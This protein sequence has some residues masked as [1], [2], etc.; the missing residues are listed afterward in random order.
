M[1]T[2]D[3]TFPGIQ[4]YYTTLD[5]RVDGTTIYGQ[6]RVIR[7][8][9]GQIARSRGDRSPYQIRAV[10]DGYSETISADWGY[11]M[12]GTGDQTRVVRNFVF[13]NVP[14]GTITIDASVT[15]KFSVG[16]RTSEPGPIVVQI[17]GVPKK[18]A[19][20]TFSRVTR[21]SLRLSWAAP[22]ANLSPITEYEV[23]KNVSASATGADVRTLDPSARSLDFD[24]LAPDKDYYF[25]VRANNKIGKGAWS[26]WVSQRT[27]TA[28]GP[29][30]SAFSGDDGTTTRVSVSPGTTIGLV[31]SYQGQR[32]YISPAME[33][34]PSTLTFSIPA[35]GVTQLSDAIPGATYEYRARARV[36]GVYG[37]WSEWVRAT[38]KVTSFPRGRYFDGSFSSLNGGDIEFRFTG[39]DQLSATEQ[40]APAPEGWRPFPGDS[41]ARGATGVVFST[42]DGLSSLRALRALF[43]SAPTTRGVRIISESFPIEAAGRYYGRLRFR[44]SRTKR[45]VAVFQWLSAANAVLRTD[46]GTV[47]VRSTGPRDWGTVTLSADR[48]DGATQMRIGVED[49]ATDFQNP[50]WVA[51][52]TL[53][54]DQAAVFYGQDYPYFDGS[55]KTG[56]GWVYYWQGAENASRSYREDA[57]IDESVILIDPDCEPVPAPPRPPIVQQSCVDD[58]GLWNRYWTRFS[59]ELGTWQSAVPTIWLEALL[60]AERQVRVRWFRIEGYWQPVYSDWET[61]ATNMFENPSFER[62]TD[63]TAV[64]SRNIAPGPYPTTGYGWKVS[65][66]DGQT[67]LVV[68]N[69][70]SPTAQRPTFRTTRDSVNSFEPAEVARVFG[71]GAKGSDSPSV[72]QDNIPVE[73]GKQYTVSLQ[74]RS[75]YANP[76]YR[77]SIST[78][79]ANGGGIWYEEIISNQTT[80]VGAWRK[81]VTTTPPISTGVLV[82]TVQVSL[83]TS[84]GSPSPLGVQTW[85]GE[86]MAQEGTSVEAYFD[87]T[88]GPDNGDPDWVYYWAGEVGASA[89][90]RRARIPDGV[91]PAGTQSIIWAST[92]WASRLNGMSVMV[93]ATGA[94]TSTAAAIGGNSLTS[95]NAGLVPGGTYTVLAKFYQE[96]PQTGT[97]TD[98]WARRIRVSFNTVAG[99][100]GESV[101]TSP[102]A[103]N[104]GGQEVELR[105]TFTLPANVLWARILLGNGAAL[106]G[107][108]VYWDDIMVVEGAYDGPWFDG[109]SIV[110][111]DLRRT[112]WL[113]D[114]DASRSALQTRTRSE[115]WYE[116]T[117]EEVDPAE[118]VGEQVVSYL[119]TGGQMVLDGI[120]RHAWFEKDNGN[121][122]PADHLLSG[123]SGAPA[124]WPELDCGSVYYLTVDVPTTSPVG[125]V[126]IT[127]GLTAV[128]I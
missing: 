47:T 111:E 58:V 77:I 91:V 20:P 63:P 49:A 42:R 18:P 10:G 25:R 19:N 6:L 104:V 127:Q 30:I 32:R 53:D 97:I 28:L 90:E 70:L 44:S 96:T 112:M 76:K 46:V 89:S 120:D 23:A 117:A 8:P 36:D 52:D 110:N 37:P 64:L 92:K 16:N 65:G 17:G 40:I 7:P 50:M 108:D 9:G 79:S 2:D 11:D 80:P 14:G 93:R 125:N 118:F 31:Q 67:G 124:S 35:T 126:K 122:I 99:V 60:E 57:P 22:D 39:T 121:T 34:A 56:R 116:P 82:I 41:T 105:V 95:M 43:Y 13:R 78:F 109:G 59:P 128:V 94:S 1:P 33:N 38:Q 114:A 4:F 100:T 119:P 74:V 107:G 54:V 26:N 102:Q 98:Q 45:F 12:R 71:L 115:E 123:T 48:P 51:G 62:W 101:V 81:I 69:Q 88:G 61:Q 29:T 15:M 83:L 85:L 86:V 84:D 87:G 3:S 75:T 73:V 55:M 68:T 103:P 106:G 5:I 27:L 21:T 24:N 66:S 72:Q 113:G